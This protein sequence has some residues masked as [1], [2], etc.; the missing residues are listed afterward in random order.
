S[1]RDRSLD[2]ALAPSVRCAHSRVTATSYFL[3]LTSHFSLLTACRPSPQRFVQHR[4]RRRGIGA[5]L[6]QLALGIELRP[7]RIEHLEEVGDPAGEAQP[8]QL[9]RP[10]TGRGGILK[11]LDS[12]TG[13]SVS[14]QSRFYF[15]QCPQHSL[16]VLCFRF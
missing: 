16:I 9:R 10:L 7:F 2:K 14:D 6:G 8:R 4:V 15:L 5:A 12:G 1:G 11:S 13:G 3:L